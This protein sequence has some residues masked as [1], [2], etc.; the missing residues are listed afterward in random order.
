MAHDKP[1]FERHEWLATH[2]LTPVVRRT[3]DG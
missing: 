1:P 2:R 3:Y